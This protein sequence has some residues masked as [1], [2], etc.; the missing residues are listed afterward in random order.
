[1]TSRSQ[2]LSPNDNRRQ[3]KKS[4]GTRLTALFFFKNQTLTKTQ[5]K[6]AL[7]IRK[8]RTRNAKLNEAVFETK[9]ALSFFKIENYIPER[10]R[11]YLNIMLSLSLQSSF[12]LVPDQNRR[13]RD[14][15]TKEPHQISQCDFLKSVTLI[16]C[17]LFVK[18]RQ[19]ML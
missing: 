14:Q 2:G 12:R 16:V 1:M 6:R 4:L 5:R 11:S 17:R 7:K 8:R 3:R 19:G 10:K 15:E 18:M 9:T 13:N